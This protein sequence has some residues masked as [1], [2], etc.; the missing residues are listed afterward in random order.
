M[1]KKIVGYALTIAGITLII[2]G[3][4]NVSG[5]LNLQVVDTNPPKIKY[6]FPANGMTYSVTDLTEIVIYA[7]DDSDVVSAT[8]F[9]KYF[10]Q[11]L[12]VTPYTQLRHP[13]QIIHNDELLKYPDVN[14][15]GRVDMT[16]VNL[17]STAIKQKLYN[18]VYDLNSDG[19]VDSTDLGIVSKYVVTVTFASFITSPYSIGENITFSFTVLDKYGN[20][21]PFSGWFSTGQFEPLPGKWKINGITVSDN[22]MLETSERKATI[23]FTCNDTS[24][25]VSS[26]SAKATIGNT[27]HMLTFI[28]N[29]TWT[30]T[31][32][33]SPGEN[34]L[35]L[36]ASITTTTP[37]K[38]NKISVTVKTPELPTFTIGHALIF[39]GA[40]FV[41]G[42]IVVL[43]K[44]EEVW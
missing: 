35:V 15:D 44:G 17:V 1:D 18:Q 24:V 42:G 14:F 40:I 8:Y 16:D 19:K 9:D 26:V 2:V 3:A 20:S 27:I 4:L 34:S 31:I 6:T 11:T 39:A 43:R 37:P 21:A 10:K 23:T 22:T 33:L 28:G 13:W 5:Y 38:L 30:T 7:Q 41:V 29:Y 36:E 32:D 25:S 12:S